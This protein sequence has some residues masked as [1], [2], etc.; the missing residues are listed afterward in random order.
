MSEPSRLR[1]EI[2]AAGE[3]ERA[4]TARLVEALAPFGIDARI[5]SID[6]V[7]RTRAA[8]LL[9]FGAT[10]GA[11]SVL[12]AL[13]D[14]GV[15]PATPVLL[16]GTPEG[17]GPLK[18]GPGFGAEHVLSRDASPERIAR[19]LSRIVQAPEPSSRRDEPSPTAPVEH[20]LE[21]QRRERSSGWHGDEGDEGPGSRGAA[22]VSEIHRAVEQSV[23][24]DAAAAPARG[25]AEVGSSPGSAP[26]SQS[27][28]GSSPGTSQIFVAA[29]IGDALRELLYA[30]D[31]R[32]FADRAP[33]DVSLP[34]GEDAAR[35]LVP[36]DFLDALSLTNDEP[37]RVELELTFVGASP[38]ARSAP[39]PSWRPS[40]APLGGVEEPEGHED[41]EERPKTSPGTPT[42]LSRRPPRPEPAAEPLEARGASDAPRAAEPPPP[43]GAPPPRPAPAPSR[44]RGVLAPLEAYL[45][46][47]RVA[48]GRLDGVLRLA[49]E[50]GPVALSFVAGELV[51]LSGDG[52]AALSRRELERALDAT[53][54]EGERARA[55]RD[56]ASHALERLRRLA[57]EAALRAVLSRARGDFSLE[58]GPVAAHLAEA[59]RATRR[60]LA[61]TLFEHASL[62][63]VEEVLAHWLPG[64]RSPLDSWLERLARLEVEPTPALERTLEL[65]EAPRELG[66][67]LAASR[68]SEPRTLAS[69]YVEA[70][71]EPGLVGQLFLLSALSALRVTV[72]EAASSLAHTHLDVRVE[73]ALSGLAARAER[74]DYFGVLG[75]ARD[76]EAARISE[77]HRRLRAEVSAWPLSD[78][79]LARLE[80]ERLRIL[81]ALDEAR[82]VLEDPRR[83]RL[84]A[85]GLSLR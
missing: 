50:E 35:A 67:L 59:R 23:V 81:A 80:P 42:S 33:I 18:E 78:L 14:D 8:A 46:V 54:G 47:G 28:V 82:D 45:L 52:F 21:L 10:P 1:V 72:L 58:L 32:I 75:L 85:A 11:L 15:S 73:E 57:E 76:V 17:T 37:G 34:R 26:G 22:Q 84:Y 9:L 65:V 79:G 64:P 60:A 55:L 68:A 62:L 39:P 69:L 25:E 16:L 2:A 63:G 7:V 5:V 38:L 20:T 3:A 43:R 51:G 71:D 41:G 36:D 4:A 83:R 44:E 40:A 70:P 74:A 77:A 19:A 66:W 29:R 13:R 56:E 61:P 53:V 24:I 49:V 30:A 31:R 6:D 12:R 27:G 48:L